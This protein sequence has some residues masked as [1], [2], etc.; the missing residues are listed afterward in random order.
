[1]YYNQWDT[2]CC[3]SQRSASMSG[4]I[5]LVANS[6]TSFRW[7]SEIWERRR[8][9]VYF[10]FENNCSHLYVL[11]NIAK[12]RWTCCNN[13]GKL[14]A[15]R[16]SRKNDRGDEVLNFAFS[17]SLHCNSIISI[18]RGIGTSSTA[19]SKGAVNSLK[20]PSRT[21][22][23]PKREANSCRREETTLTQVSW[24]MISGSQAAGEE[25]VQ[26]DY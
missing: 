25:N 2:W 9:F 1:M 4:S 8:D 17:S 24:S 13:F 10:I 23:P 22:T 19:T 6:R 18:C 3:F 20:S 21:L 7:R 26:I 16:W 12:M 5:V 15:W 11:P 14:S